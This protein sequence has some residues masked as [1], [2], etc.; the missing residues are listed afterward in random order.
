M[1]KQQGGGCLGFSSFFDK[2]C[3]AYFRQTDTCTYEVSQKGS[4]YTAV[5][6]DKPWIP[7]DYI[8]IKTFD[9]NQSSAIHTEVRL[10]H[11]T[12]VTFQF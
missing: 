7:C 4:H 5:S 1:S 12:V 11:L 10:K 2:T 8:V 9:G 6:V 3:A